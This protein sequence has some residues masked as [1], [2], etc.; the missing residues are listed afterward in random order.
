MRFLLLT[1]VLF[2]SGDDTLKVNK[3]C[4]LPEIISESSG[5]IVESGNRFWT[6][7]D[8]GNPAVLYCIDSTGKIVKSID[9]EAKNVDW[10]EMVEY[11]GV[12]YLGDFGNNL[13]KRQ[14]LAIH[15]FPKNA[16]KKT[17]PIKPQT[18]HFKYND[19]LNFPAKESNRHY[20]CEAMVVHE[21][22]IYLF[23]K[24][25]T[26]PFDGTTRLYV[27]PIKSGNQIARHINTFKTGG[28]SMMFWWITSAVAI[29][30]DVLLLST[31]KLFRL[32]NLLTNPYQAIWPEQINLTGFSQK[33]AMAY[34]G[35]KKIYFTD[36]E[37]GI[38]GGNLS[39]SD[40]SELNKKFDID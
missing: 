39:Y 35:H 25:R 30:D 7:N 3:L 26:H 24:N 29:K 9:I 21:D 23:T 15:F 28:K 4:A 17:N 5:L 22:S 10:E 8:G 6:H 19:Q 1:L 20:D 37:F 14:N 33:E 13:N 36:E 27:L 2:T 32:P 38:T 12:V 18:I 16:L 40:L 11:N 31:N 34:D